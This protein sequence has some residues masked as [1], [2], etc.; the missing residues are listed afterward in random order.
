MPDNKVLRIRKQSSGV[1]ELFWLRF[2]KYKEPKDGVDGKMKWVML[3]MNTITGELCEHFDHKDGLEYEELIYK[4]LCF[5]YLTENTEEIIAPRSVAG[6]RKTGKTSNDFNF[7][8]TMVTS[9]WN[10]TSIRTE[11]FLVSGHFRLQPK[12]VG[13]SEYENI[14]IA[15]F[16]KNGYTRRAKSLTA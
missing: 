15:P 1:L 13:R 6:T 3:F 14:Y 12:G 11:G 4:L 7:P 2:E 16:E 8:L 5:F 9:K 10:I